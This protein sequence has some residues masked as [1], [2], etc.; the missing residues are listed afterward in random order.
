VVLLSIGVGE[1]YLYVQPLDVLDSVFP[2]LTLP[3]PLVSV[4]IEPAMIEIRRPTPV[5]E[6][7]RISRPRASDRYTPRRCLPQSNCF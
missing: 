3:F 7:L 5:F 4:N 1:G 2:L 6:A